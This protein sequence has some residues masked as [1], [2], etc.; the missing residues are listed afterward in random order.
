MATITAGVSLPHSPLRTR[1]FPFVLIL[2]LVP[3]A[4]I[5]LIAF[6]LPV[7]RLALIS[8]IESRGGGVLTVNYTLANYINF[9]TDK[10]SFE[11][12]YNSLF[13]GF[14][15]TVATLSCAYPIAL[16]LHRVSPKWRNMLFV[17][18]V[19]PL[20]VSSVVRTYGWMV[21]LGDQGVV[22]GI[23]MY[24]GIVGTPVRLVNNTLGI[25]IGMVEILIPYM[26]LSL[27]AGFG[28]L[29]VVFEEA[30]ASLGANSW[31][32]FLRIIVPLTMP[33]VALGCL[34]CFV[35][36]ISS[37][38]TPKL[39]GGGRVFLLATEIYDQAMIQ[40]EWPAAAATSIIV[41]I[42]FGLALALY[43]RVT[44]RFD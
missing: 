33:G 11:L 26:A 27:I 30:A 36:S 9:F 40:L 28:R 17:V 31:T 7:V 41:L 3:M 23:L 20:L 21:L 5:N 44:K 22:N 37:F 39:L 8:F 19:S 16:F 35:L 10:F 13:L 2:L 12:I 29:D 4:I 15:V 42:I 32:R 24:S 43:S 38:I 18:T 1:N 25:F 14:G 6:V 34:L